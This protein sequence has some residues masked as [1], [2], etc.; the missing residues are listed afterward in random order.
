MKTA[1]QT[2]WVPYLPRYRATSPPPIEEPTSV[3]SYS[4]SLVMNGVQIGRQGVVV[5][6]GG[7]A[8]ED[9]KPRRS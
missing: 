7:G 5:V 6:S 8:A 1:A 2:R 3:V 4:S 9:P